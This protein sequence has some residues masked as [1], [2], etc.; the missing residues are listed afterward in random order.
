MKKITSFLVIIL[1]LTFSFTNQKLNAMEKKN[2]EKTTV[3]MYSLQ[4]SLAS[5]TQDVGDIPNELMARA[6]ELGL[7][8]TGPQLWQYTGS[9]GQPNTKFKLDICIPVKE[10]KGDPGKFKFVTLP[11]FKCIS[12]IHKGPW[13]TLGN[14]YQRIMGEISRKSIPM[15]GTSREIYTV[16]D[17]EN[18]ENCVTEVQV[19]IY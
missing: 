9:D 10:A 7:V 17:F 14:T 4:S 18:Q 19:Q 5:M 12:E 1:T 6:Q 13:N 15:T 8:I 2:V 16:C 11:E 3:L